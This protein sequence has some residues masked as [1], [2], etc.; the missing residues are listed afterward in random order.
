MPSGHRGVADALGVE[1]A[2]EE[3]LA[4]RH[5]RARCSPITTGTM[6]VV[7]GAVERPRAA[8]PRAQARGVRGEALPPP[9]LAAHARR[10]AAR[11]ASTW[12]GASAQEK[13]KLRAVFTSRSRSA[14]LPATKAPKE[15]SVLPSVPS[16]TSTS[17]STPRSS[18]AA[19]PARAE[20][21]D[22][23]GVVEQHDA[24]RGAARPRA[25]A[26]SGARSPS[27]L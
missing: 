19:A 14:A 4:D 3:R 23:V 11:A 9:G 6:W 25:S 5:R 22:A 12:G 24:R 1:A 17:P 7:L 20:R 8:R 10:S 2:L 15:P 21:A 26:G 13:M 18:A 27:M 16:S